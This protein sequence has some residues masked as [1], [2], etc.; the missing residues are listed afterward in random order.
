MLNSLLALVSEAR[1]KV[2][3]KKDDGKESAHIRPFLNV[4]LQIWLR[5]LRRMVGEVSKD[6]R[7]RFADDLNEEQLN[8]H[9]PLV[10]CRECGS[11]GWAGLKLVRS[12]AIMGELKN[13]YYGFFNHDPKVVYLFPEEEGVRDQ[14]QNVGMYYFCPQCLNVTTKPNPDQCPSCAHPELILVYMPDSRRK[15]RRPTDKR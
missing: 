15:T 3:S 1:I 8:T 7:L 6:P 12:S 9:L 2:I 13:F 4:R 11:M 14:S 10:H 5:E